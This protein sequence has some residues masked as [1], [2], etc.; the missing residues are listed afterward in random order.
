MLRQVCATLKET[1]EGHHLE[2]QAAR[3]K[4]GSAVVDAVQ[5]DVSS[6]TTAA[7]ASGVDAGTS[8]KPWVTRQYKSD[9]WAA[10]D[11]K[12]QWRGPEPKKGT[13]IVNKAFLWDFIKVLVHKVNKKGEE[14]MYDAVPMCYHFH[15]AMTRLSYPSSKAEKAAV[16][17]ENLMDLVDDTKGLL[18]AEVDVAVNGGNP[19][20]AKDN[21][22]YRK[23]AAFYVRHLHARKQ[24]RKLYVA[25][26]AAAVGDLTTP[27]EWR[28][29]L[30][31]KTLQRHE[32]KRQVERMARRQLTVEGPHDTDDDDDDDDFVAK[33]PKTS[34]KTGQDWMKECGSRTRVCFER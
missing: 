31:M 30:D 17:A 10:V 12:A 24:I 20:D 22:E 6:A 2:V 19:L 23:K 15:A 34:A 16:G 8:Q 18:F 25:E 13:I 1:Y 4:L 32:K 29:G 3:A 14:S 5:G 26:N 21:Q 11:A 27:P 28:R 7:P 9:D 33:K